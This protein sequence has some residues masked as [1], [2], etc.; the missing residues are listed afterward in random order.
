[1]VPK[2]EFLVLKYPS[3]LVSL[4]HQNETFDLPNLQRLRVSNIP[5][6]ETFSRANLN[7]PLLRSVHITFVK[8]LRLGNLNDTI[9]YAQQSLVCDFLM[10]YAKIR[11]I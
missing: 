1:M 4:C 8:K 2:M 10:L 3:R 6:M 11:K 9:S 5:S 7:T